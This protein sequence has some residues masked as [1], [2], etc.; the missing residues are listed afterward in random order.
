MHKALPLILVYF[1]L[2]S[3]TAS[4]QSLPLRGSFGAELEQTSHGIQI[5]TVFPGTTADDL[6]IKANDILVTLNGN[7]YPELSDLIEEIQTWR[8]GD[9]L[10]VR[11][12]RGRELIDNSGVVK[13]RTKEETEGG[14]TTYGTVPY[15]E[16][17]LR[18]ILVVPENVTNPPTIYFLQGVGCASIDYAFNPNSTVKLLINDLVSDGFAVYRVEKPGMGDSQSEVH[19]LQM[20]FSQEVSAFEAG[21]NT[22]F[23][24]PDIDANKIILFGE[25]LSS[26][27]VPYL[28]SKYP[29]K[30]IV[31]WGGLHQNWYE[32]YMSLHVNQKRLLGWSEK[33]IDKN[34]K[35]IQPF[36]EDYLLNGLT[37]KQ[38]EHKGYKKLVKRYFLQDSTRSGLHHYK[39][40]QTLARWEPLEWYKKINCPVLSLAGEHDIHTANSEWAKEISRVVNESNPD[41]GVWK[42]VPETTHHYFRIVSF[43][44][45]IKARIG[46]LINANFMA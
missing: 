5:N 46:G 42:I 1:L 26:V 11:I 18:S 4:T 40:F 29:V 39:Y 13:G 19:C 14:I 32:Y 17:L 24:I 41:S 21:V 15:S 22:L 36:Y 28:A 6:F 3:S 2:I 23:K 35:E 9:S 30:G 16:G 10:V 37:P 20:D 43:E 12:K 7:S 27:T 44:E 31:N 45:Y 34:Y 33:E 38:L 8:E 25:S